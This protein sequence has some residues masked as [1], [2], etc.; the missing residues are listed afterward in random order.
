MAHPNI[1]SYI[2]AE[3]TRYQTEEIQLGDNWEWNMNDHIQLIYHLKNSVFWKGDNDYL[4]SFKNI[5]ETMIEL[6]N[7]TEDLEVKDIVFYIE[8]QE[9]RV[10]SFLIKKYHDEVYIRE[11]NVEDLLDGI[12]ESDNT[13]GGVIVQNTSDIPET[14]PLMSVAFCDQ[15]DID[16]GPI[17]FKFHFSPDGLRKMA[18]MGWGDPKNGATISLDELAV[19]ADNTKETDGQ[20]NSREDHVSGKNVE[21][22]VVRGSLPSNYLDD[23]NNMEDWFGQLHVVAFYTDKENKKHGVCLYRKREDEGNLRFFTAAPVENRGLGRGVGEKMIHPQIWTNFSEIHKMSMLE[24][25][26]KSIIISS[27]PA[28][29]QRRNVRDMDNLEILENYQVKHGKQPLAWLYPS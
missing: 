4:R 26:S 23:D 1:F 15:S 21:I 16:N 10:L 11:H 28:L 27:D 18:K 19:L 24:A 25:G 22:Y 8:G 7:W 5:I 3:E 17:G 2:K 20:F 14:V 6:A 9:N 12:T 13:Y 29:A